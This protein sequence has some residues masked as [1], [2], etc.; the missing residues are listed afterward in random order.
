MGLAVPET[1]K[2]SLPPVFCTL[3]EEAMSTAVMF[4]PQVQE[5]SLALIAFGSSVDVGKEPSNVFHSP[6]ASHFTLS[7]STNGQ[8]MTNPFQMKPLAIYKLL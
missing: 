2:P 6:S 5:A 7:F 4:P 1:D 8:K 3:L